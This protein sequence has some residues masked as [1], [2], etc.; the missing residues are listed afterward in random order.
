MAKLI[1]EITKMHDKTDV[2]ALINVSVKTKFL[3]K[4]M[5]NLK[6]EGHRLLIFSMSKK[7]LDL[8]EVIFAKVNHTYLRI[9]GDT[10]IA[11]RE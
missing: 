11:S 9:D 5:E 4:L 2:E 6:K 10:E 1:Q 7:M 8:L 3:L